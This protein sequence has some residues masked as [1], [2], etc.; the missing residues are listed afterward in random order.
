MKREMRPVATR[1]IMPSDDALATS[2]GHGGGARRL[3]KLGAER[4]LVGTGARVSEALAIEI[5]HLALGRGV[6]RPRLGAEAWWFGTVGRIA[7]AVMWPD[8]PWRDPDPQGTCRRPT[9][10]RRGLP[11]SRQVSRPADT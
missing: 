4:S 1:P 5:Q 7:D 10:T 9:E 11:F 3:P 8:C 6:E 2:V